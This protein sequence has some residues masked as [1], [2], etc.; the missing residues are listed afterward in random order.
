MEKAALEFGFDAETAR[1]ISIETFSGAAK[2]A[3]QSSESLAT[4]RSRVTSKGG[5]TEAAL[6]A[7]DAAGVAAGIGRGIMAADARGRE[8]GTQM[9]KD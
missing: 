9:G 8:L 1:R 4:L 6:L 3:A 2:L 7:F 5:T